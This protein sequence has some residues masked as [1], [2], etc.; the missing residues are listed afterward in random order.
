[1]VESIR[2]RLPPDGVSFALPDDRLPSWF[3]AEVCQAVLDSPWNGYIADGQFE[4]ESFASLDGA[5]VKDNVVVLTRGAD[6]AIL[7]LAAAV[8]R[9]VVPLGCYPGYD[10]LKLRGLGVDVRYYDPSGFPRGLGEPDTR[11]FVCY[12]G[13]PV[14]PAWFDAVC[15]RSMDLSGLVVDAT[16]FC[17]FSEEFENL[18]SRVVASG[19]LVIFSLSK[20]LGVAAARLGGIVGPIGQVPPSL[21]VSR[22]DVFQAALW[23]VFNT[24]SGRGVART[25]LESL[26]CCKNDLEAREKSLGYSVRPSLAE[27]FLLVEEPSWSLISGLAAKRYPEFGLL[28]V[29]VCQTNLDFL[30]AV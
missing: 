12:P 24:P 30:E 3:K 4:F 23:R 9:V 18:A 25:I 21:D 26:R 15:S 1:M 13:N 6:E 7:L 14:D 29:D 28:R 19:G 2:Y 27:S 8:K 20:T 5:S 10:R 22:I 17:P 11:V 16:Y